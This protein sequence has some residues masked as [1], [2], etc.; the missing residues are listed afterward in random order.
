MKRTEHLLYIDITNDCTIGCDMCMYREEHKKPVINLEFDQRSASVVAGLINHEDLDHTVLSGKGEPFRNEGTIMALLNLSRGNK[1]FHILTNGAWSA[2][3]KL[4]ILEKMAEEKNDQYTIRLSIDPFHIAKVARRY[5]VDIISYFIVHP[6]RH[7][8]LAIRSLVEEKTRSRKL[9]ESIFEDIDIPFERNEVGFLDDDYYI[10]DLRIPVT[11]KS[12][13]F[14]HQIGLVSYPLDRYILLL[15]QKY[16]RKF[17]LGNLRSHSE[18]TG[19]DITISMDGS[20]FFYGAEFAAFGNILLD[21]VTFEGLCTLIT[22][23]PWLKTLYT[24]PFKELLMGF[25]ADAKASKIIDEANNP[26]WVIRCLAE[27]NS[28]MLEKV[29]GN[30]V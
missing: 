16:G 24:E 17:T 19:L 5:Y 30:K 4:G 11:Y 3:Q 29:L 9:I 6:S 8:S 2:E 27:K 7:L 15:E 1:D 13:V 21:E 22:E 10:R 18:G 23:H 12:T 26:Y 20:V 14:P 28:E 25:R